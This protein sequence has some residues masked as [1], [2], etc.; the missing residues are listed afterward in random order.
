MSRTITVRGTGN[1]TLKPD[2]TVVSLM[3]KSLDKD[4]GKSAEK[5]SKQ[6]EALR[7]ALT[8]AG[9]AADALKTEHFNV[10]AEHEGRPDK[11]GVY[12]NYFLGYACTHAMK[13]EFDADSALLSRALSAI[14][15][16]V[17]DPELNIRFTVKD[18]AAAEEELLRSAAENA[19]KKAGI[20]AAASGVQ[21]G[22]LLSID[23]NWG[24]LQVFSDTNCSIQAKA[25][26]AECSMDMNVDP[27]DIE[28]SDSAA[29][30]WEIR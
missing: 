16:C 7:S 14:A 4:Y 26:R 5:A 3:L 13:L 2:R 10:Y 6:L 28:L 17:A 18:R 11:N 25:M 20:L 9:F 19:R 12:R 22:E 21:L 1:V 27:A 23:Y 24:E 8:E 29:F 30:V 15:Q